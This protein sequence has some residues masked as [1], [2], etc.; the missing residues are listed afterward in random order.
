MPTGG[1]EVCSPWNVI[2][3]RMT[4]TSS[5]YR[6]CLPVPDGKSVNLRGCVEGSLCMQ[7]MSHGRTR[8]RSQVISF[9][10]PSGGCEVSGDWAVG[11]VVPA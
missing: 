5:S 4:S 3:R 1:P 2:E 9:A 8:Q 11:L 7:P 10:K 6:L